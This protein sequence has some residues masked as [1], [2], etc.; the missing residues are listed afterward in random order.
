M[1]AL[2]T[3]YDGRFTRP[4]GRA[5]CPRCATSRSGTSPNL[6]L[7]HGP[8]SDGRGRPV[9]LDRY[10]A[11]VRAAY[12]RDQG[13]EP[14][15]HRDRRRRR[16]RAA[17]PARA[18][19][20]RC[21]GCAPSAP[22]GAASTPTRST[23]TR[24]AA[25]AQADAAVPSWNSVP[26]LLDELDRFRPGTPLYI[27]EAGY[28]TAPTP[29][30]AACQ[31]PRAAGDLPAPDLRPAAGAPAAGGRRGL[32]QPPGQPPGRAACCGGRAR[33]AEPPGV[34]GRRPPRH[35]PAHAEAVARPPGRPH[36]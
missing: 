29:H 35:D 10:A 16:P 6:R 2:A 23:S 36:P 20:G 7:L 22:P 33:Q 26:L 24:R 18:A 14:A 5:R 28:T 27:T 15:R 31:S 8:Q 9:A 30:P 4:G 25:P 19:S 1:E 32:V 17:R 13:G 21:A 12:P 11:M 3:R 34:P